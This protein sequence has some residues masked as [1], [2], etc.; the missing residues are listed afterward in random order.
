MGKPALGKVGIDAAGEGVIC[1]VGFGV[2]IDDGGFLVVME[3]VD[4]MAGAA[5]DKVGVLVMRFFIFPIGVATEGDRPIP[6]EGR[7]TVGMI[8]SGVVSGLNEG[9]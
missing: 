7:A 9:D 1:V 2:L 3:G 5:D 6:F 8:A 4:C